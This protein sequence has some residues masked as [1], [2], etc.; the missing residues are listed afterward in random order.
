V[1]DASASR[2]ALNLVVISHHPL[3][4]EGLVALAKRRDGETQCEAFA[5]FEQAQRGI[6]G[7]W[8]G[9]I[10]VDLSLPGCHGVFAVRRAVSSWPRAIVIGLTNDAEH[11]VAK[12]YRNAGAYALLSKRACSSDV[13]ALLETHAGGITSSNDASIAKH[14]RAICAD[15]KEL[16]LTRRQ[17]E[18]LELTAQ[19]L[20]N[21]RIGKTLGIAEATIKAHLYA[22]YRGMSVSNRTQAVLR[23]RRLGLISVDDT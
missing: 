6:S 23:A 3:L 21:K 8:S 18:V 16:N 20:C 10:A 17:Q 5:H 15:L 12:T 2:R 4:A 13:L 9:L 14:H 19:G 1:T 11:E 22:L 7:T